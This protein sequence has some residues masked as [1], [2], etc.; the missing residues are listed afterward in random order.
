MNERVLFAKQQASALFYHL[1][2][3][4]GKQYRQANQHEVSINHSLSEQPK[5]EPKP[6]EVVTSSSTV[7]EKTNKV[8]NKPTKQG[9]KFNLDELYIRTRSKQ[10]YLKK[11]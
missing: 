3:L 6:K 10:Y 7:P 1:V 2:H 11:K 9:N 8:N 5:I 4:E